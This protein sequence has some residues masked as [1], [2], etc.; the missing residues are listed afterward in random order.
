MLKIVSMTS[1]PTPISV[2]QPAPQDLGARQGPPSI[3]HTESETLKQ[4]FDAALRKINEYEETSGLSNFP[5][6]L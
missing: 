3:S 4:Q 2:G 5:E 6:S 1:M